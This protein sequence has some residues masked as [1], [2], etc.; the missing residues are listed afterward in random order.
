MGRTDDII[1]VAGHRM[2]TGELEEVISNHE[3]IA[4]CAVI[5]GVCELKGQIP[6]A[7][8]V[9]KNN[10]KLSKKELI[11]E[12]KH[13][14]REKI[15][16]I[17]SLKKVYIVDR[18]PKTRSGKILRKTIRQIIDGETCQIPSTID[19]PTVIDELKQQI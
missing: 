10:V 19:D 15:G 18:L 11:I 8:V 13:S 12:L 17:A 7:L 6:I 16:A 5:G 2:S 4:E 3:A 14:I 9:M 1:N